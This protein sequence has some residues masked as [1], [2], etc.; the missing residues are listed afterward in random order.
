MRNRSTKRPRLGSFFIH[1]NPLVIAGSLGK[2]VNLLLANFHP[3][4]DRHLLPNARGQRLRALKCLNQY[5][6]LFVEPAAEVLPLRQ[7]FFDPVR[8]HIKQRQA[9]RAQMDIVLRVAQVTQ[10]G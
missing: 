6:P 2:L 1:M 3:V 5:A 7:V 8:C 10:H 9:T 4:A